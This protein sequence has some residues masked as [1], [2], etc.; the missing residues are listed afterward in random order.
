MRRMSREAKASLQE[1]LKRAKKAIADKEHR[2]LRAAYD[3]LSAAMRAAGADQY[4]ASSG[5][6]NT[7]DGSMDADYE[8]K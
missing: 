3:E 1:P 2:D 6:E 7:D 8:K 5:E 4:T